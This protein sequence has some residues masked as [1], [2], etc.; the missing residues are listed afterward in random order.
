MYHVST[1]LP[2]YE[3]DAQQLEKKRHIG[4]DIV[5]IIFQEGDTPFDPTKIKSV[6]NHVFIVIRPIKPGAKLEGPLPQPIGF[7]KPIALPIHHLRMASLDPTQL[8]LSPRNSPTKGAASPFDMIR[9][10]ATMAKVTQF[11]IPGPPPASGGHGGQQSSHERSLSTSTGPVPNRIARANTTF[12]EKDSL[13]TSAGSPPVEKKA[14]TMATD[15]GSDECTVYD[16][17]FC[18]FVTD[19]GCFG[20]S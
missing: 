16:T 20:I 15:H 8:G 10:T 19:L 6:F 17:E 2:H 4:N 1:L 12:L 11:Q 5:V 7:K 18:Q 9:R 13:P 3:A 14:V